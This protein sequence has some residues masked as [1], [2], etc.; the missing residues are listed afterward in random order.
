MKQASIKLLQF[1][2]AE[3]TFLMADLFH[4]QLVDGTVAGYCAFDCNITFR[5][6]EYVADGPV[7]RRSRTRSVIGV[8][9]DT[10]NLEV[11]PGPNDLLLG[12]PWIVAANAGVLDGATLALYRVFLQSDLELVDGV[13]LFVGQVADIQ[14]TRSL[15]KIT[16]NSAVQL[17]NMKLPRNVW[18]P[19][20]SHT[21]FDDNCAVNRDA[22]IYCIETS[23]R[24]SG[25]TAVMV[26]SSLA[27]VTPGWFEQGYIEFMNGKLTGL[28]RT[29]KT[30]STDG[31]FQ[32]LLPLPSTPA[33]GDTF[34]ARPGC[35][36]TQAT[37]TN[38][39]YNVTHFKAFPY[40]PVAESAL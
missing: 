13:T 18:Q 22:A 10:L 29:I 3:N 16:A 32:L 7:I 30:C 5:G 1:L 19:G 4:L 34:K 31:I 33:V 37:C 8:E 20:C 28:R 2:R 35:D 9:V 12:V 21:L 39:F 40:V 27:S 15:A 6:R 26:Y 24:S 14:T 23:V 25:S 11:A 38:K 36:K 17:L